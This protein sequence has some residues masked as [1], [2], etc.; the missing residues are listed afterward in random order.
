M[1]KKKLTQ[2][3]INK[4]IEEI[5]KIRIDFLKTQ[6]DYGGFAPSKFLGMKRA[7]S[8][9]SNEKLYSE[10]KYNVKEAKKY[11][12]ERVQISKE[13]QAYRKKTR[14]TR[15][16]RYNL[17]EKNK[18]RAKVIEKDN[19]QRHTF[20]VIKEVYKD[21][22]IGKSYLLGEIRAGT[23]V[24]PKEVL[25]TKDIESIDDY[26]K[27]KAMKDFTQ[28]VEDETGKKQG[29]MFVNAEES[30]NKDAFY[31]LIKKD[32]YWKEH[33]GYLKDY[34]YNEILPNKYKRQEETDDMPSQMFG[35]YG[36]IYEKGEGRDNEQFF[37]EINDL[38]LEEYKRI[39]IIK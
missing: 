14:K 32:K 27:D 9:A 19:Y 36:K 22:A 6:Q 15:E 11:Y 13:K 28:T 26:V 4:R 24:I 20:Q 37:R 39:M 1:A 21:D 12:K 34:L 31:E 3:V 23:L 2:S 18:I 16:E 8:I 38:L 10:F 25:D 17:R 30:L 33:L 35:K 29:A 7:K 5:N